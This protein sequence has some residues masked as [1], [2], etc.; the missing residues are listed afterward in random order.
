MNVIHFSFSF[1]NQSS[2]VA[3]A[4]FQRVAAGQPF[5]PIEPYK[6]A[7]QAPAQDS[8]EAWEESIRR[9]E[10]QVCLSH[11]FL[12][13]SFFPHVLKSFCCVCQIELG[14]ACL[15]NLELLKRYGANA[16]IVYNKDA[17][18]LEKGYFT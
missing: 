11:T 7:L 18:A 17:E 3:E 10:T 13:F 9:A 4:E 2:S 14:G 8:V 15:E 1:F 12:S 6:N 16:W 5:V